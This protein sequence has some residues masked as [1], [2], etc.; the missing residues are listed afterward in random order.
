[1][2]TPEG[3]ITTLPMINYDFAVLRLDLRLNEETD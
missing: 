1:M 3:Q 2:Y